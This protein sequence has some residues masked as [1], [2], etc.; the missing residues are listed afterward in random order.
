MSFLAK[1]LRSGE[2]GLSAGDHIL[3]VFINPKKLL[4]PALV[5][6]GEISKRIFNLALS[7][8]ILIGAP[9]EPCNVKP[10]YNRLTH[11]KFIQ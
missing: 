6:G 10:P 9:T 8:S 1:S 2:C 5:V 7:G 3:N 4:N 11:L